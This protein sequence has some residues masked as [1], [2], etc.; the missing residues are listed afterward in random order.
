[1]AD[2]HQE[3]YYVSPEV[4][5]GGA[6]TAANDV[7]ALGLLLLAM[8]TDSHP[9]QWSANAALDRSRKELDSLLADSTAFREALRNGLL[10]PVPTPADTDET[11]RT[12]LEACLR[13]APGDRP[14]AA[15]ILV[16]CN[17]WNVGFCTS[18]VD[19]KVQE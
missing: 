11:L 7:Y 12:V 5:A 14:T 18:E 4:A 16:L 19:T 9:W 10:T 17:P 8:L 15:D 6:K 1:A 13:A 2:M 3:T